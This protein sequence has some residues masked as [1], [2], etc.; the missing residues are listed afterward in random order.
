MQNLK[1]TISCLLS[2]TKINFQRYNFTTSIIARFILYLNYYNVK[3][4]K[5]ILKFFIH[6]I[7]KERWKINFKAKRQL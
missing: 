2:T 7:L 5:N 4:F 6:K 1:S 3:A